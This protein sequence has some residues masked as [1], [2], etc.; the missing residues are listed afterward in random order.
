MVTSGPVALAVFEAGDRGRPTLLMVHGWPDTHRLWDGVAAELVDEFHVVA[1]D[2]RGMGESGDPDDVA[3]FGIEPL[4]DDLLAVAD[5]VSPDALVHL[6]AHDWGSVQAW[7]AVCRPGAADRFA[8]M[9]SMSGPSLDHMGHWVRRALA[10]RRP[11]HLRHVLAQGAASAYVLLFM[12]PLGRWLF[13]RFGSRDRW[14]RFLERT[15]GIRPD[16]GHHRHALRDDMV[17]GLRYYRANL[18]RLRRPRERRTTVPVL[19]LVAT[20]DRAI[21]P[22]GLREADRWVE[23]LERREL[24]YG[25]WVP[26]ARPDLVAAETAAF[27]RRAATPPGP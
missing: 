25:H 14:Q 27:I 19:Q 20:R 15:E 21:R 9:T 11:A 10:T 7:E 12:S 5:A 6:L 23:R 22:V 24:A 18:P 17:S 16:P 1:Y 26:L 2:T 8:T 13:G 4:A 3:G